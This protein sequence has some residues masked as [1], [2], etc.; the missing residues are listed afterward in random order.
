MFPNNPTVAL[1]IAIPVIVI[2]SIVGIIFSSQNTVPIIGFASVICASIFQSLQQAKAAVKVEEVALQAKT[3]VSNTEE[4]AKLA[5]DTAAKV[6]TARKLLEK[7]TQATAEVLGSLAD[8][9]TATHILVNSK[10]TEQLKL[11]A[12]V[13]RRLANLTENK[14]DEQAAEKAE[15]LV[16]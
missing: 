11:T 14:E 12:D 9:T 10:M 16:K 2:A 7:N 6:E 8:V 13:S 15:G 5:K 1:I 4:V 3:V